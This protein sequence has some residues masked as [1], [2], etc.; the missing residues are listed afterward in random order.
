M[1]IKDELEILAKDCEEAAAEAIAVQGNAL[2]SRAEERAWLSV[3]RRI[4]H[5][6]KKLH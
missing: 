6:A 4:R 1:T 5:I 3:A 2:R